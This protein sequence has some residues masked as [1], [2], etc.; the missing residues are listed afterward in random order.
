[1]VEIIIKTI[2]TSI[3]AGT[4]LAVL[5]TAQQPQ[6]RY[7]VIDI[8]TLGGTYSLGFAVN[9]SG[10][11]AGQAATAGQ[12]DGFAA[13]A[14]QWNQRT[15]IRNLGVLSPPRFTACPSCN[16]DAAAVGAAGEVAI[17]SEI[18]TLDPHGEDFGQFNPQDPTH[19]TMRAGVWRHG[20]MTV[21]P[22]LP[23]G[24]NA[25]VF[26]VN[27]VGQISGVAE[28]AVA[29][30]SCSTVTPFQAYRFQPVIWGPN[31]EIQKALSP[32]KGDTVAYAFTINDHGQAVGQSGLCSELGLPPAAIN[33]STAGHAVLW[34]RDGTA[35][36]LGSLGG[37]FSGAS[38]INNQGEVVG[39]ADSPKDGTRHAFYWTR[40]TGMVDYGAW[41]GAVAT[42]VGCC[43]TNNDRGEIV[44]FSVEPDNPY[45]GRALVWHGSAPKDLNTLVVNSGPFEYLTGAYSI[46]NS[47]EIV[48][49]GIT[50]KGEFHACLA[51]PVSLE[52]DDATPSA[53]IGHDAPGRLS[54]AAREL[55]RRK[56]GS[57]VSEK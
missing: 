52:A 10:D 57:S 9:D 30:A 42:V 49:Q 45:F 11:V 4:L 24:N 27:N 33:A 13:T 15:G 41:P 29:D 34:E 7:K 1:M 16:S 44:G 2:F 26:W 36:N 32:L 20:A 31:G 39:T 51:V 6:R 43:H 53:G 8:G 25:N 55:L 12:T 21:L 35:V 56:A 47:G 50:S 54:G 17:G 37:A 40:K 18:A 46:N 28:N 5:A 3:A 14:Y 38:S 48:C 22:N 23:G 19:R